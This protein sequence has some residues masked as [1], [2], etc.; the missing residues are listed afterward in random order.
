MVSLEELLIP[1]CE[2]TKYVKFH[3][4]ELEM[5]INLI[6][7]FTVHGANPERVDRVSSYDLQKI[8]KKQLNG[9][10]PLRV[11]SSVGKSTE[12][13]RQSFPLCFWIISSSILRCG[14]N[15]GRVP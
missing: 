1:L 8:I 6:L 14:P 13:P 3:F 4:G 10:K 9:K 12:N 2:K 11:M 15:A 5:G 7:P